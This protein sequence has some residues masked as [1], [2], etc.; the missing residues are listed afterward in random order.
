MDEMTIYWI[1][2]FDAFKGLFELLGIVSCLSVIAFG[3]I[4]IV[5]SYDNDFIYDTNLL[6]CIKRI[7][8]IS[9]IC[10]VV[11]SLI[12]CLFPSTKEM[13]AIKCIPAIVSKENIEKFKDISNDMFDVTA[14][15]IKDLKKNK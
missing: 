13:F 15:Y 7:A 2:R 8:R 11:F 12:C 14:N 9:C 6:N 1:T 5:G 3:I 10:C 4:S